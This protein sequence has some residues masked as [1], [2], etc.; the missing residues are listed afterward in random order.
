LPTNGNGRL[1]ATFR[2]AF[3]PSDPR[4]L[5][6]VLAHVRDTGKLDRFLPRGAVTLHKAGW[7]SAA[8]HDAGLVYTPRGVF[9]AA[10]MTWRPDG[11][12][13]SSDVFA[14]RVARAELDLLIPRSH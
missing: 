14:G 2:G 10:V 7:I 3:T 4:Y 11:A 5:L 1:D 6:C 12:G 8:R 13:A 9:V